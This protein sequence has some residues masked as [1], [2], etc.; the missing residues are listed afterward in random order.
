[1]AQTS[2]HETGHTASRWLFPAGA[3]GLLSARH[4]VPFQCRVSVCPGNALVNSPTAHTSVAE[5]L[6][7]P[8]S[9]LP[10]APGLGLVT[11]LHAAASATPG[12]S[13]RVTS[14]AAA[15]PENR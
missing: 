14:T 10:R 5:T 13:S 11:T 2:G 12:A 3:L 15:R 7:T 4:A 6:A 8:L 9:S 1:A